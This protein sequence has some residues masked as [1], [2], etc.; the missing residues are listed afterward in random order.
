[1]INSIYKITQ[2]FQHFAYRVLL[3][4]LHSIHAITLDM[5]TQNVTKNQKVFQNKGN[6]QINKH[7][8][9]NNYINLLHKTQLHRARN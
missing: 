4:P 6:Q 5:F 3:Y 9:M 8:I 1:V 2:G 7:V